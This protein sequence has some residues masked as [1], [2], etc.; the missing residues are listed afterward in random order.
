MTT[1]PLLLLH[2]GASHV[3]GLRRLKRTGRENAC[4]NKPVPG[5]RTNKSLTR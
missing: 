1:S 2:P 5:G 3:G 4:H